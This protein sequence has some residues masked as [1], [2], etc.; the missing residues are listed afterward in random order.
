MYGDEEI[1]VLDYGFVRLDGCLADDLSVINSARVS[2][3]K[4]KEELDETDIKV[5]EFLMKNRHG[6]PFEH[7]YFRFH[8]KCPI[9]VMREWIRHRISSFNEYSMRYSPALEEFY[10]PARED[11]RTQTGKPG[12]YVFEPVDEEKADWAREGMDRIQREAFLEYQRLI[13]G[14][15]AREVARTVLPVAI[16][17]EFY[18]SINAR[19]LMNFLSL[20]NAPTAQLEIRR[21]A[22]VIEKIFAERMPV[23]AAA[24]V[25]NGR[26]A[27]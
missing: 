23:T 19:S 18:W 24:F 6:T 22:E 13:E 26:E 12:A 14:G 1:Q 9:F 3:A 16:Y 2:F 8:A 27:P 4:R 25:E 21:Y 10:L 15:I 20:R 17:T 7:N 5:I 11:V